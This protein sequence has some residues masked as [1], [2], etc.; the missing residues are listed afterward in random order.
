MAPSKLLGGE[1]FEVANIQ[2]IVLGVAFIVF[3][4][5]S[6]IFLTYIRRIK[7]EEDEDIYGAV[8]G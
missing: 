5:V 8:S 6:V 1:S 2:K 3:F 4:L 7:R